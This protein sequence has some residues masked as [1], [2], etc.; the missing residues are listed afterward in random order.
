MQP[1]YRL[2]EDDVL[3]IQRL[4]QQVAEKAQRLFGGDGPLCQRLGLALNSSQ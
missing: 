2:G 1:L 3:L 4:R